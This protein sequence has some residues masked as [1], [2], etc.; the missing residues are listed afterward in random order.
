MKNVQTAHRQWPQ[1]KNQ[2]FSHYN[3]MMLNKTKLF[4]KLLCTKIRSCEFIFV[5]SLIF[6]TTDG[7]LLMMDQLMIFQL[8]SGTK[9]IHISVKAVL[10]DLNFDISPVSIL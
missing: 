1:Q 10:C 3:E 5:F 8:Y 6:N 4:G 7:P 9:I 2:F